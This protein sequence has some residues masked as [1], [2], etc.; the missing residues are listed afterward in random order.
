MTHAVSQQKNQINPLV[1]GIMNENNSLKL[2]ILNYIIYLNHQFRH[3]FPS[4]GTIAAKFNV[5]REWVNKLLAEW[6]EQG[7]LRYRQQA[8]NRSCMYFF[9]PLLVQER[10][11]LKW[12]LS[13][14]RI[15][16]CV[17]SL[18]IAV[19]S[20]EFTL[21]NIKNIPTWRTATVRNVGYGF[22]DEH[23]HETTVIYLKNKQTPTICGLQPL[24]ERVMSPKPV[25][26]LI[27]DAYGL[28]RQQEEMLS[29]YSDEAL[30]YAIKELTRQNK[31]KTINAP[32][33]WIVKVAESYKKKAARNGVSYNRFSNGNEVTHSAQQRNPGGHSPAGEQSNLTNE[34]RIG[35]ALEQESIWEEI[36]EVSQDLET[37]G[38]H[39]GY[40]ERVR[41]NWKRMGQQPN[42]F[43][44]STN[45]FKKDE[46]IAA[47]YG[48]DDIEYENHFKQISA[49]KSDPEGY[50]LM[51]RKYDYRRTARR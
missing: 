21:N 29:N 45:G 20:G 5:S 13:A 37:S 2:D 44:S 36:F 32:V 24:K 51:V 42:E 15:I 16:L 47:Q 26:N 28:S 31:Q 8:F 10:E 43:P 7:V 27:A 1:W 30:E 25:I 4:Q 33:N 38:F 39:A 3:V 46:D 14:L 22:Y 17:S 40:P 19:F 48:S 41:S 6:K 23:D 9:N 34:Q 50:K 12:K 35:F 49:D 11:R 18:S